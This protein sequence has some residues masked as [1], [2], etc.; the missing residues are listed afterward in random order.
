MVTLDPLD[1]GVRDAVTRLRNQY[2]R[3]RLHGMRDAIDLLKVVADNDAVLR[4]IDILDQRM[5]EL[6]GTL[7]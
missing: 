3:G 5:S 2:I 4:I 6:R 1:D 7:Q